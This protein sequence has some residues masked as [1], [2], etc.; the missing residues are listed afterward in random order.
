MA[1]S[2]TLAMSS[3]FPRARGKVRM[4]ALKFDLLSGRQDGTNA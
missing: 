2:I 1:V 4:G 3:P